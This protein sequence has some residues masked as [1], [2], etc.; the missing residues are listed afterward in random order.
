MIIAF[1]WIYDIT[2][3]YKYFSSR[4]DEQVTANSYGLLHL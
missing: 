2:I 1:K 4:A 3:N